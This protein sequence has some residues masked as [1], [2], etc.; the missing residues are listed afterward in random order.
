MK[1]VSVDK[2][3]RQDAD[4][5]NLKLWKD[6]KDKRYFQRL[7]RGFG[8]L[9]NEASRK[10]S[11]GSNIPQ[12]VFKLEAAQ[13]FHDALERYN[14]DKGAKLNTYLYSTLQDKLKRVNFK[15]QKLARQPER[16]KAGVY[17]HNIFHNE[18]L[19]LEDKLGREAST[20]ELSDALDWSV[21]QI[22]SFLKE[23]RRDLSLNAELENVATFDE[24]SADEAELAMHYYDMSPE[25]QLVFDHTSGLHGKQKIL[26]KN[27]KEADWK[28]IAR[29]TGLSESK[30]QK[31]RKKLANRIRSW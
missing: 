28:E 23:D 10:A 27:Q 18:K 29:V 30:V 21:P 14:P 22:E 24:G 8:G 7:Y 11:Y 26:K 2:K 12:S 3:E 15:Y 25:E 5:E 9:I 17:H 13:Q 31:I 16:A 20:Q 19:F 1:E 6:T 4:V